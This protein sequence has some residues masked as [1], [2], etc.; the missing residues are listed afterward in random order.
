MKADAGCT[1]AATAETTHRSSKFDGPEQIH[2]SSK[3]GDLPAQHTSRPDV[4]PE[5]GWGNMKLGQ[6]R[7]A[8][9]DIPTVNN[10]DEECYTARPHHDSYFVG[11]KIGGRPLQC[12]IDTGCTTNILSKHSFDRLPTRLKERLEARQTHGAMADGTRLQFYG[13]IRLELRLKGMCL[14]EVF[15]VGKISEDVILGMPFLTDHQCTMVFGTSTVLIEGKEV[16]CT[17]RHGRQ[18]VSEIQVERPVILEPHTEQMVLARVISPNYCPVGLVES[19]G[20]QVPIATSL[21][22]PDSKGCLW[23]R[24][25]NLGS[26]SI[27]LKQGEPLGTYTAVAGEQAPET[28]VCQIETTDEKGDYTREGSPKVPAH[29]MELAKKGEQ[30]CEGDEQLR[31]FTALL[32]QYSD[33]FSSGD[34]DMGRT[35][36]IQHSI[37]VAPGTKPIR[38]PPP[39]V[40][41]HKRNRRRKNR[42]LNY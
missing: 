37:P 14:E 15:V 41:A 20:Q 35:E 28:D 24:G 33:V 11:G 29:L 31:R 34:G 9:A 1:R 22:T 27:Q 25:I 18:L 19:G 21:S 3:F 5:A 38:L 26:H 40:W 30:Q 39:T 23:V 36:L 17:D 13:V 4:V 42:W 10:T 2:R 7:D 16:R 12:L 32:G 6:H 8:Q